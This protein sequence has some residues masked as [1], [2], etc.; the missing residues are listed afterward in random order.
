MEL[1]IL[2][3]F[4]LLGLSALF[5][6][7]EAAYFS[8]SRISK[9]K[10]ELESSRSARKAVSLLAKPIELLTGVLVGNMIVNISATTLVTVLL[11]KLLGSKGLGVAIPLMSFILLI[12]GE[13]TPKNIMVEYN[14]S[15]AKIFSYPLWIIFIILRPL[16]VVFG[17]LARLIR[18]KEFRKNWADEL[19]EA[20][21][22]A[23]VA[24]G[25]SGGF[26]SRPV[27]ESLT[28]IIEIEKITAAEV[29]IPRCEIP[30]VD[31]DF[32]LSE[33]VEAFRKGGEFVLVYDGVFDN[34]IGVIPRE[35]LPMLIDCVNHDVVI[36]KVI[37]CAFST[38]I[39]E[40]IKNFQLEGTTYAVVI[41]E[42]SELIG[43]ISLRIMIDFFFIEPF[44]TKPSSFE[45]ISG[46]VIIPAKTSIDEFN[47]FFES[48]IEGKEVETIGGL[49]EEKT[50]RI[51]FRGEGFNIGGFRFIVMER[52]EKRIKKVMVYKL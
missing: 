20:D 5:S 15:A 34:V 52:D 44:R 48:S 3:V 18:G 46:F 30:M 22:K 43:G 31:K 38:P 24:M 11:L 2:L 1:T 17:F 14:Y 13:I 26:I 4:I 7:S 16:I 32:T 42:H 41:G 33:V 47:R 51:P 12:V 9:R 37:F 10:L 35:K 19:T 36:E 39:N 28:R 50:G 25:F 23:A 49:I 6:G 8:L 29:M 45:R 40:L 21:F 27:R